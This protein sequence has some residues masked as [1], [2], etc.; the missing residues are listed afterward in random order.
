MTDQ[1]ETHFMNG[2]CLHCGGKVDAKGYSDGGEVEE[3]G[4]ERGPN[5][6]GD[7]D[8]DMRERPTEVSDESTQRFDTER[9]RRLALA[10]K[11]GG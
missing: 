5:A 9:M 6:M 1:S 7:E 4:I 8:D 2:T 11:G 10:L 3:D